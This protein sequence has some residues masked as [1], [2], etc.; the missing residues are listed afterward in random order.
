MSQHLEK[1]L[2]H[3]ERQLASQGKGQLHDR[4]DLYKKFLK[5]EEHRLRLKHYSGAG[6]LEIARDRANL[7]DVVLRHLFE[8]AIRGAEREGFTPSFTLLAIGGYGRGEL[9]PYSDVDILFVHDSSRVNAQNA[10][11][12]EQI[13]YMLWDVGFKVGHATRSIV[14]AIR[15]ANNDT[16]TKT[17]LLESRYLAGDRRIHSKFRRDFFEHCVRGQ[18]DSYLKWRLDNQEERHRKYGGSVFMQE[19]NVKNGCGGLRDYQTMQWICYFRDGVMSTAKLVER[20]FITESD[21]RA[22]DRA[23]DF[24]LRVRT[25]LQY[26]SKRPADVL[27]LFFQGQIANKFNY[28]QKNILRRSEAFM[29]DYY[30]H[31]RAIYLTTKE[32]TER[33]LL[34]AGVDR[35]ERH[36][37]GFLAKRTRKTEDFD[38]FYS[39]GGLLYAENR[40]IFHEDP[41]RLMRVFLHAQQRELDLSP[42]L[43]QLIRRRTRLVNR[44]FQYA[45]AARETFQA[46]LSRKGQVGRILRMMHEVDFLGRY[47]PEFGELTCLVQHEFFHQYTADEHT[48]VCIEMLDRTIG[49]TDPKLQEYERLFLKFEDAYV[50]YLALLLHDTGKASGARHHAEA[51]AL[52]AQKVAARLQLSPE[53]RRRLILLVDHHLTL[54]EIAQRRNVEDPATIAEFAEIVR[55]QENL[56]ALMLVTLADG[57]GT[58]GQNWS[59]WKESLVWQLYHGAESYLQGAE[60]F[61]RQRR[62]EREELRQAVAKRMARDFGEEIEAH[63]NSMPDRY[64]QSHNVNE[65]IGHLRLFRSLLEMRFGD[66]DKALASVVRWHSKPDQGHS[67]VWV[68]TWD[69]AF[70]TAKIAGSFATALMNILS[71]DVYTRVDNLMLGIFRVCDTNFQSV[72]EEREQR[73]VESVLSSALSTQDFDFAPLLEKVRRRFEHHVPPE[74]EF[75]TKLIISNQIHPSYTVIDL[76]TP[77]RLGLLYDVLKC[78]SEPGV[79]IAHSRIATEKGAAFDTFYV[80]DLEGRKLSDELIGSYL[81]GALLAAATGDSPRKYRPS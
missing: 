14:D 21:R 46:I 32:L 77:D 18:V 74:L 22:I 45:R 51:S 60:Q 35:G 78:L 6:G 67:E 64:F 44:T 16:L 50:L 69:R 9:N 29:R 63:F 5:I 13:L 61:F 53:R 2:A 12:I 73:Q 71:A 17:S 43:Q 48:L 79:N 19:P 30:Q 80:T 57:Q 34:P 76:Q 23:Y 37:F 70:L 8:G 24:L 27:T 72:T 68:C 10:S 65:I 75:P 11:I 59:D 55:T 15:L 26:L 28:P 58:S 4:L 41:F 42:E 38:G 81:Q 3:A 20:K 62:I 36:I 39:H 52:N 31:A 33:F 25:E 49:T 66:P 1:I 7:L 56:D 47:L 40:E 54:S